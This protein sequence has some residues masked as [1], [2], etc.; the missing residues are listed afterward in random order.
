MFQDDIEVTSTTFNPHGT[1]SFVWDQLQEM[2]GFKG[3][4]GSP[5][6]K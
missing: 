3:K 1:G 4:L 6:S 5:V 2:G